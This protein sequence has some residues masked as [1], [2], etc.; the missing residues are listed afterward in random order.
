[1]V[2]EFLQAKNNMYLFNIYSNS[3]QD[4]FKRPLFEMVLCTWTL[5]TEI[6]NLI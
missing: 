5:H 2:T 6:F 3:T 4:R 1:M